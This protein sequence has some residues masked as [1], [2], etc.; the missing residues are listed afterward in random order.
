MDAPVSAPSANAETLTT[1]GDDDASLASSDATFHTAPEHAWHRNTSP[2]NSTMPSN[3]E[4]EPAHVCLRQEAA[5]A[6][7]SCIAPG[8]AP[9]PSHSG[10][11]HEW[12]CQT[13]PYRQSHP[14]LIR[15][16]PPVTHPGADRWQQHPPRVLTRA[17]ISA[18]Y[19]DSWRP[20]SLPPIGSNSAKFAPMVRTPTPGQRRK[21]ESTI[22]RRIV[23]FL[24]RSTLR[25]LRKRQ[26][27]VIARIEAEA[28]QEEEQSQRPKRQSKL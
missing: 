26:D 4:L 28:A 16:S 20:S 11:F 19:D 23:A 14:V 6:N 5:A 25:R 9:Y 10:S 21:L 24:E 12:Q 3:A 1:Y 8:L 17:P 22:R 7:V 18:I 27:A 13:T 2:A 15:R